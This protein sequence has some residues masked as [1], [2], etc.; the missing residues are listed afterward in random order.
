MTK[1]RRVPIRKCLGCGQAKPKQDLIR[2]VR[3]KDKEVYL[4]PSGKAN[5]RGAYI[6]RDES[7]LDKAV[8]TKALNR[9]FGM[10]INSSTYED[11]AQALKGDPDQ[12]L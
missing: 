1:K 8:R 9:A 11:L 3:N 2:V 12:G 7:C 5:G 10:E 6:C 4:D